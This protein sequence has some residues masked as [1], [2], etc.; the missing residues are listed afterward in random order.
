MLGKL[1]SRRIGIE[2][3]LE[4]LVKNIHITYYGK[5]ILNE[6]PMALSLIS[7]ETVLVSDVRFSSE[8]SSTS[9][10][11]F[12]TAFID[13]GNLFGWF[14]PLQLDVVI[15]AAKL[16]N[17][18]SGL[19]RRHISLAILAFSHTNAMT[20]GRNITRNTIE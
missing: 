5:S 10:A 6:L 7:F 19:L 1:T 20:S 2:G 3:F 4:G 18:S 14:D 12:S 11:R 13:V 9:K 16:V 15:G 17:V 8:L